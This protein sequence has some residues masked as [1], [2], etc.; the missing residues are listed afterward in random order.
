MENKN[1]LNEKE[2]SHLVERAKDYI[3]NYFSEDVRDTEKL[4]NI[5]HEE[6][7]FFKENLKKWNI[8]DKQ[9]LIDKLMNELVA[10]NSTIAYCISRNKTMK[11]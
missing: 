2:L 1:S 5:V 8:K 6:A 10:S 9:K 3:S 7:E 11:V 4:K